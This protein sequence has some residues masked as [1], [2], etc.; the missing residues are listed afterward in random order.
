MSPLPTSQVETAQRI[1]VNDGL[2]SQSPLAGVMELAETA[3][4]TYPYI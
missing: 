3:I 2:G 4:L 1:S